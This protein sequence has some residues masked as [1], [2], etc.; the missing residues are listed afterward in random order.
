MD[1]RNRSSFGLV[2]VIGLF[3]CGDDKGNTGTDAPKAADARDIDA[4]GTD[5]D[6]MSNEGGEIRLEYLTFA[7]GAPQANR[8][9]ATGFFY[10]GADGDG[11]HPFPNIPGC[12][13][14]Q[15]PPPRWPFTREKTSTFLDVGQVIIA[16]GPQQLTLAPI[17]P[18]KGACSVTTA[19]ACFVSGDCPA[20]ETCTGATGTKDNLSRQYT[21]P[22][23]FAGEAP[24]QVLNNMGPNFVNADATYDIILTGSA[25]WPPQIFKDALYVPGAW[26]PISPAVDVNP[27]LQAGAPLVLTFQNVV[28]VNKP[29]GY[30]MNTLVHFIAAPNTAVLSCISEGTPDTV[31]IS[32][33]DIDYVRTLSPT[34]GKF[35]RQHATHVLREMTD[36]V[37][38]TNKRIDVIGIWC[39]NYTFT[40]A[41]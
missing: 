33:A 35:V 14:W 29:A 38:H 40:V 3:A 41:P 27:V 7:A 30:P 18:V 21:G 1:F 22:W 39:F 15:D 20:T 23:K 24:G 13:R 10:D 16:G 4:A 2:L 31:T 5:V 6:F 8:V 25:Q 17:T 12:T 34:G 37:T 28:E 9:R 11:F 32:A 26:T 36:G 19:T